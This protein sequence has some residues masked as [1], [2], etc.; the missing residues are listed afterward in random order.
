MTAVTSRAHAAPPEKASPGAPGPADC[1]RGPGRP[2]R[3]EAGLA[4]WGVVAIWAGMLGILIATGAGFGNNMLVLEVS[5]SSAGFVL[6]LAG[7]VWA[8]RRLRPHR[9]YL[10]QPTRIGGAVMLAVTIALSLLGYAFGAWLMMVAVLPLIAAIGLE[11]LS[12]RNTR[13][14]GAGVAADAAAFQASG[15]RQPRASAR[16]SADDADSGGT[17]VAEPGAGHEPARLTAA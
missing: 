5:G 4:P 3:E 13:V 12:R 10:R 17:A 9:G 7:A 2:G 1:P 6:L 8:D 14:L 16:P 15:P 11:I